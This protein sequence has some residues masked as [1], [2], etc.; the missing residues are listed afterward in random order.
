MH[1]QDLRD[2]FYFLVG[3]ACEHARTGKL[4]VA[5]ITRDG[6]TLQGVPAPQ[7]AGTASAAEEVDDS[8]FARRLE[9]DGD[10]VALDTIVELRV[11]LPEDSQA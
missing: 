1:E 7:D 4:P 11:C 10:P 8:G 6:R 2:H 5:V 3:T 9:I